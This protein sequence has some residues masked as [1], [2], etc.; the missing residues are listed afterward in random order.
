[1]DQLRAAIVRL[2]K[3]GDG[4]AVP[5]SWWRADEGR[6][7]D[8]GPVSGLRQP[9]TTT[10]APRSRLLPSSAVRLPPAA[11]PHRRSR[12]PTAASPSETLSST[13]SRNLSIPRNFPSKRREI[14]KTISRL[15]QTLPSKTPKPRKRA[16]IDF[17]SRILTLSRYVILQN[18]LPK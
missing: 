2:T 3:A 6:R 9:A 7:R 14:I 17:G 11:G 8:R 18:L 15:V 10:A 13:L 12:R 1:M 4:T 5:L 16:N